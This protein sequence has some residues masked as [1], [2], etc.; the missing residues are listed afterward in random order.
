MEHVSR[1]EEDGKQELGFRFLRPAH[2][3]LSAT[4]APVGVW[5]AF[6]TSPK[7]PLP[8]RSST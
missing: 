8:I 7:L 6:R 3:F 2:T 5:T 1:G 4:T